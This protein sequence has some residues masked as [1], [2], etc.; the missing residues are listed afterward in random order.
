MP[1]REE[2]VGPTPGT[3]VGGGLPRELIEI[4]RTEFRFEACY[5]KAMSALK[6]HY[7]SGNKTLSVLHDCG[8]DHQFESEMRTLTTLLVS[9]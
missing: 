5:V 7:I 9:E 8:T 1:T 6:Q 4:H 3:W 2:T